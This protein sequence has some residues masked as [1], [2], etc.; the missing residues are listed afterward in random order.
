MILTIKGSLLA[1]RALNY[2]GCLL[3]YICMN[4]FKFKAAEQLINGM[5][6]L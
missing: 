5:L 4:I 1:L 3:L 2:E 6:I